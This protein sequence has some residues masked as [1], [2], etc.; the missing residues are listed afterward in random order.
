MQTREAAWADG[1]VI[2]LWNR[3]SAEVS[4]GGEELFRLSLWHSQNLLG[5]KG[6]LQFPAGDTTFE[7]CS[8]AGCI[9]VEVCLLQTQ[10]GACR[11]AF[12]MQ[13]GKFLC[14]RKSLLCF[15]LPCAMFWPSCANSVNEDNILSHFNHT[16]AKTPKSVSFKC[17]KWKKKKKD[18]RAAMS[19]L[20]TRPM[21]GT[22][23]VLPLGEGVRLQAEGCNDANKYHA[24]VKHDKC[25]FW[26]EPHKWLLW[27]RIEGPFY[28]YHCTK[29]VQWFM[30]Q[31][32]PAPR[33]YLPPVLGTG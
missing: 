23:A 9:H 10:T 28:C 11:D 1:V 26:A 22:T 4:R 8:S 25:N 15:F 32:P 24:S 27:C 14:T 29:Y 18:K 19:F 17:K 12:R 20:K 21:W 5:P 33:T 6:R 16:D 2:L 30:V 7:K 13:L 3:V 31:V